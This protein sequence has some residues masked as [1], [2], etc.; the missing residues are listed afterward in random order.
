MATNN[1]IENEVV[2]VKES[3][4]ILSKYP[5]NLTNTTATSTISGNL[6]VSGTLTASGQGMEGA[7]TITATSA[8]ALSVGQNGNTNP[9]FNVNSNTAS[10]ATGL[11]VISAVA[12]SGVTLQTLSSGNNEALTIAAK[13][14]SGIFYTGAYNVM[15]AMGVNALSVGANGSVNPV[16]NVNSNTASVATGLNLTGAAAGSGL[17][18]S[19]TSS[20][21]AENLTIDAKGTGTITLN[22]TATG[23]VVLPA[24]S[25]IGGSSPLTANIT[26]SSATAFS[27]GQNGTTNPAFNINSSTASSATGLTVISAAA[28]G[29]VQFNVTSSG[30]NES[31]TIAPKGS[32]NLNLGVTSSGGT[33]AALVTLTGTA[34]RLTSASNSILA[35]GLNG[36]TNPAFNV[37]AST[38][39]SATGFNVKSAAAGGGVALS[40]LSSGTN[41]N[42]TFAAKGNGT[43]TFNSATVATAGGAAGDGVMFG[44]IGVGVFTGTGAPTFSAMNGSIYVNSAAT[45]TTTRIY[46]NNS[47]SGT[48]GTTWTNLTTAA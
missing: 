5:L 15:T 30:T 6:V 29:G 45:T 10:S 33:I 34:I 12:G 28:A 35:A 42:I 44:S 3:K 23:I 20:G 21:S 14:T 40:T 11:S 24:G 31:L 1:Y 7:Q 13:G 27:V 26:S 37:D 38:A 8:N 2:S 18:V 47:G 39:S 19:T 22:G 46:V 48:A 43:I 16:L 25:T 32:G 36:T 4:A 17:A 41:E 9:T